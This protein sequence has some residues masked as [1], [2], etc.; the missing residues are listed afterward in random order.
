MLT[1]KE[2]TDA[3]TGEMTKD[4]EEV[5]ISDTVQRSYS[6]L[7]NLRTA[8]YLNHPTKVKHFISKVDSENKPLYQRH[9]TDHSYDSTGNSVLYQALRQSA[10]AYK[11]RYYGLRNDF[12]P[13]SRVRSKYGERYVGVTAKNSEGYV[14]ERTRN[15]A[16]EE[17]HDSRSD[18]E[19]RNK[20]LTLRIILQAEIERIKDENPD[21]DDSQVARK[22]LEDHY[23]GF[24]TPP[25]SMCA[26]SGPACGDIRVIID[27]LGVENIPFDIANH[28]SKPSDRQFTTMNAAVNVGN[29][30]M[31]EIYLTEYLK[32]QY[33]GNENDSLY[34]EIKTYMTSNRNQYLFKDVIQMFP[35]NLAN[36]LDTAKDE[37]RE[38][39]GNDFNDAELNKVT[40]T[41]EEKIMPDIHQ[42]QKNHR[43]IRRNWAI[44]LSF[45]ILAAP[46]VWAWYA[47]NRAKEPIKARETT[48]GAYK[49]YLQRNK[50]DEITTESTEELSSQTIVD[51]LAYK[52]PVKERPKSKGK[53][54]EW[55]THK[56]VNLSDD[57]NTVTVFCNRFNDQ[58]REFERDIKQA[59]QEASKN[60]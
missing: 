35:K 52:D 29:F 47:Y 4:E 3:I 5:F 59:E 50:E 18:K 17:F 45:T 34:S 21:L 51:Y 26:V 15:S 57:D 38:K 36:A 48:L 9:E 23:H 49:Q 42:A 11:T 19:K 32:M 27:E 25:L 43:R 54:T 20:E 39:H 12:R 37:L 55:R 8:C 10:D 24:W 53:P 33:E 56:V 46:F 31:L 41:F 2:D 6:E 1:K 13:D 58:A 14:T 28:P 40:N 60:P 44:G 16:N 30:K 22:I 7:G